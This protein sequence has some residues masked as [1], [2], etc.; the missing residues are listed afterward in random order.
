M[1]KR[2]YN[3]RLVIYGLHRGGAGYLKFVAGWLSKIS[4]EFTTEAKK[5]TK[6]NIKESIFAERYI[7]RLMK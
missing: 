2:D 1:N 6:K 3:A 4:K 7:A 5:Q